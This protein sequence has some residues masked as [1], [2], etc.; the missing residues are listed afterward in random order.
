M[1]ISLMIGSR[2]SQ[3]DSIKSVVEHVMTA[4]NMHDVL[5]FTEMHESLTKLWCTGIDADRYL[6]LGFYSP[7]LDT[8]FTF[9]EMRFF[10]LG[11]IKAELEMM[12]GVHRPSVAHYTQYRTLE[13]VY[14]H[15][16]SSYAVP[17]NA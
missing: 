15:L 16:L 6:H 14:T 9:S 2:F 11:M 3:H 1:K 12:H 10:W 4:S 13:N 8:F 7:E 5:T 17:V